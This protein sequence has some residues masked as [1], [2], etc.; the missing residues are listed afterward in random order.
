MLRL[1]ILLAT[2]L[3][4]ACGRTSSA[5]NPLRSALL[6]VACPADLNTEEFYSKPCPWPPSTDS[7]FDLYFP[8]T[9]TI[10]PKKSALIDLKV[11]V[12]VNPPC[13]LWLLPR[14]SLSGTP[15]RL[16]NSV[17]LIDPDYTGTLKVAVDNMSDDPYTVEYGRRLFQLAH[18]SLIRMEFEVVEESEIR[19][20]GE[21]DS[22][23]GEGGFGS[24]GV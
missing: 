8:E 16:S 24:T 21:D 14:S 9:V 4:L 23:R 5:F 11:R 1:R 20:R 17:G 12:Q 18:P 3:A 13:G 2:L 15:L 6:K 10:P 7:G 19:S 22:G